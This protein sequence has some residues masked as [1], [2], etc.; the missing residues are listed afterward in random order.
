[1]KTYGG[2]ED[3]APQIFTSALDRGEWS[4]SHSGHFAS[5][6]TAPSTDFEGSLLGL[7]AGLDS[8]EEKNFSLL[9]WDSIPESSVINPI[10]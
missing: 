6:E 3:I 4:V 8:M 10:T 2:S 7:R 9:C 1:M 5:A